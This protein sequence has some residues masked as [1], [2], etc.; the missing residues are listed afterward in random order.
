MKSGSK[1]CE[2]PLGDV[3]HQ[4]R[5]TVNIKPWKNEV[6]KDEKP[7]KFRSPLFPDTL[8]ILRIEEN[9]LTMFISRRQ[10]FRVQF[11][12]ILTLQLSPPEELSR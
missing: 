7:V 10:T 9:S 12:D 4:G 8:N 6:E 2:L 3:D 1:K 5:F 11:K